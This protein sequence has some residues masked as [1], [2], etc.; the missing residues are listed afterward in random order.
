[1]PLLRFD[2]LKGHTDEHVK[3]I[4]DAAHRAVLTAFCVPER[5]RYQ[6]VHEH[7]PSRMIVEDTGLGLTRSAA[8]IV[9]SVTSRPR[10]E[11]S[12]KIFYAELCRELQI[13]CSI[14]A[15]DVVV[16]FVTNEDA[17]WSFGR[18]AAQFITREL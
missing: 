3:A 16:S 12:K 11:Q 13:A 6:I 14:N 2:I 18:G 9:V 1:M 5:D 15:S 7:D 10:T 17:D 8:L 4:L